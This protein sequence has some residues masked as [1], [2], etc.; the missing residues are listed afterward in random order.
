[1]TRPG[2]E[3]P[4]ERHLVVVFDICSSTA[5][6]EALKRIDKLA[7]WRNL[8]VDLKRHILEEGRALF[9]Q[10]YKFSGDGWILLFPE[11]VPRADLCGFLS[12]LSQWF[13]AQFEK[14]VSN[15]LSHR[16]SPIGLMFGVDA[17]ELIRLEINETVEYLGRAINV[18]SRLQG[19]TKQLAGGPGDKALFSRNSFFMAGTAPEGVAYAP[20]VA[21][22]RNVSDGENFQCVL[23]ETRSPLT[24]RADE[25]SPPKPPRPL[26][27]RSASF[28]MGIALLLLFFWR[29]LFRHQPAQ[30]PDQAMMAILAV[31]GIASK[32]VP[33]HVERRPKPFRLQPSFTSGWFGGIVGGA[34]VGL[35][36]T[37]CYYAV[38][39]GSPLISWMQVALIDLGYMTLLGFF[40]GTFSQLFVLLARHLVAEKN[41]PVLLFNE[42]V[43]GSL[44]GGVGGV[45]SGALGGLIFGPIQGRPVPPVMLVTLGLLGSLFVSAGALFY[46]YRGRVRNV[47]RAFVASLIPTVIAATAGIWILL[48]IKFGAGPHPRL[49]MEHFFISSDPNSFAQGGALLGGVLGSA[50][51]LQIGCT[52]LFY[53]FLFGPSEPDLPANPVSQSG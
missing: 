39:R 48:T 16:P 50:L 44:G 46:E 53:R 47:F 52:L 43:A 9:I 23:F 49:L 22:L 3:L 28:A 11:D 8:H 42:V 25:T 32:Y 33:D 14:R 51:G 2:D 21:N 6:L 17:G 45:L 12:G 1:M 30:S 26:L 24:T 35:L 41:Y 37:P 29:W 15:L 7:L 36:A 19:E 13:A 38:N 31:V 40:L 4:V 10:P 27:S 18:A 20:A 5:I 34:V